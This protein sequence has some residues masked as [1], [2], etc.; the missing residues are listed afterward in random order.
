[1]AEMNS[2]PKKYPIVTNLYHDLSSMPHD[3]YHSL[4]RDTMLL[5]YVILLYEMSALKKRRWQGLED[6]EKTVIGIGQTNAPLVGLE[7][8][9][10]QLVLQLDVKAESL[11]LRF[12]RVPGLVVHIHLLSLLVI[13]F[14]FQ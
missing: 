3:L 2:G 5:P 11:H 7:H 13:R 6:V 4:I 9:R 14:L 8:F 12:R 10:T 1:M